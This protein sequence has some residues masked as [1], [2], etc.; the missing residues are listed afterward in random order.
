MN[1]PPTFPENISFADYLASPSYT[2]RI[3]PKHPLYIPHNS[4]TTTSSLAIDILTDEDVEIPDDLMEDPD[5]YV[6]EVTEKVNKERAAKA[7]Y[8][9]SESPFAGLVVP[10]YPFLSYLREAE[11]PAIV[12]YKSRAYE[13]PR[14]VWYTITSFLDVPDVYALTQVSKPFYLEFSRQAVWA[15]LLLQQVGIEKYNEI[16]FSSSRGI[17]IAT[18]ATDKSVGQSNS[19]TVVAESKKRVRALD[20]GYG[21]DIRGM[22]LCDYAQSVL[23]VKLAP[24]WMHALGMAEQTNN[25]SIL[26]DV[27]TESA[28]VPLTHETIKAI[29]GEKNIN[30]QTNFWKS[31]VK[32]R[33]MEAWKTFALNKPL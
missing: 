26:N 22:L 20:L 6:Y 23:P 21:L 8:M 7:L 29:A 32:K 9:E 24:K 16:V 31:M 10:F 13:L 5:D 12:L 2:G 11:H 4:R 15:S 18:T 27:L 1:T 14:S 25:I 3:Q 19:V 30:L 33:K 28:E 17:S